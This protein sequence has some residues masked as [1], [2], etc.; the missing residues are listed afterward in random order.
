MLFNGVGYGAAT[1]AL[2]IAQRADAIG[3]WDALFLV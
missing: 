3:P 2:Y 1:Q